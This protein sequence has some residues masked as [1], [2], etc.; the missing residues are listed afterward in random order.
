MLFQHLFNLLLWQIVVLPPYE[1]CTSLHNDDAGAMRVQK[2]VGS[3][4]QLHVLSM[5][6]AVS[7]GRLQR[8]SWLKLV[9]LCW[10]AAGFGAAAVTNSMRIVF[11]N[12]H[13]QAALITLWHFVTA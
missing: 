6:A 3:Q 2:V 8:D 12:P 13:W 10:F 4:H 5:G 11:C 1:S 7:S 9:S